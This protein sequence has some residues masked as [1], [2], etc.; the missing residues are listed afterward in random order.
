[1]MVLTQRKQTT[2]AVLTSIRCGFR[3]H[4]WFGQASENAV[5]SKGGSAG[6]ILTAFDALKGGEFCLHLSSRPTML[7]LLYRCFSSVVDQSRHKLDKVRGLR[8][9]Y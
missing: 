2:Q 9:R 8:F 4:G 6:V 5:Y 7:L 3:E 1:M